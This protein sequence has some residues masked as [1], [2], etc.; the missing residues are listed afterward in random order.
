[1]EHAQDL[2]DGADDLKLG[3][4]WQGIFAQRDEDAEQYCGACDGANDRQ[5]SF[6]ARAAREG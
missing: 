3:L 5:R 1:M 6:L 4:R 2:V